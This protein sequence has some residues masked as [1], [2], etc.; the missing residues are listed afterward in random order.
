MRIMLKK[1]TY[2]IFTL[3]LSLF[4]LTNYSLARAQDKD[5]ILSLMMLK[6]IKKFLRYKRSKLKTKNQR[7]GKMLTD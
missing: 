7:N 1:R 2:L 6:F 5:K 4:L 3:F